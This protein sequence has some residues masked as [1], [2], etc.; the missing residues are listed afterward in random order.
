MKKAETIAVFDFD[1]VFVHDSDAIYKKEAWGRI[2]EPWKGRY[3]EHFAE[4]AKQFGSGRRGGRREIFTMLLEKLKEP[5]GK[6]PAFVEGILEE[7]DAIVQKRILEAGLAP[8]AY[9]ALMVLD[10]LRV[11][12]YLNSGTPTDA[13]ARTAT[14]LKIGD[15]FT[16]ILGSTPAPIGGSKI[17]NLRYVAKSEEVTP[18][19]ILMV[20]DSLTDWE[21]AHEYGTRFVGIV[22][23]WNAWEE[24]Q[25]PFPVI[26]DLRDITKFL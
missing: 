26:T 7:Y 18:K 17:E 23:R 2:L 8:G 6:N 24:G 1:G 14:N 12:M 21:A 15:Y 11:P 3:E 25:V 4:V 20:G 19:Q 9:E 16:G 5:R 13:L 22:N 10:R